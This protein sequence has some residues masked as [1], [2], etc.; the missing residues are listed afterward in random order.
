[1]A[2]VTAHLL[3]APLFSVASLIQ[4][5]ELEAEGEGAVDT[6][7]LQGSPRLPVPALTRCLPPQSRG[8]VSE[9]IREGA[10]LA[11]AHPEAAEFYKP[12]TA[13]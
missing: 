6:P 2:H 3:T 5:R 9:Q 7:A 8:P 1:M 12:H 4:G 10:G 11:E 13:F